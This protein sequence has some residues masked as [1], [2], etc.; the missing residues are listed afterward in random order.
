MR[1]GQ[2][3]RTAISLP[4]IPSGTL[5]TVKEIGRVFVVVLFETGRQGYY[6]RRQLVPEGCCEEGEGLS[7]EGMAPLGVVDA[8]VSRGSHLCLLPSSKEVAINAMAR[9]CTAGVE[10]GELTLCAVPPSW[11]DYFCYCLSQ[12]GVSGGTDGRDLKILSPSEV[13]LPSSEFTASAQL[14]RL[15][16]ILGYLA[17]E[18]GRPIRACGHAQGRHRYPEWWDYEDRVTSLL[19]AERIVCL[20]VY[21]PAGPKSEVWHRAAALH[22]RV[23]RDDT[24]TLGG[25]AGG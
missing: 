22:D 25:L 5:G 24:M 19:R 18:D 10:N 14:E 6:A 23:L 16:A 13:Y 12:L 17:R 4:G 9:F 8:R 7:E 2:R 3:V 15:N 1:V 11:K 20:C 21:H